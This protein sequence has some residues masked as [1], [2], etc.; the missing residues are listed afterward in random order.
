MKMKNIRSARSKE[1]TEKRVSVNFTPTEYAHFLTMKEESGVGSMSLFIKARVFN[2]TFRVIKVD[3][4]LDYYQKLTTLYGKF[5]SVGVNYNQTVVAMKR[6]FT[7]KKAF[8]MLAKLEK[9]TLELAII[10]GKIVQLTREFQEKWQH[11]QQPFYI[12]LF[13][14]DEKIR[15]PSRLGKPD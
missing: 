8:A 12:V 4:S 1:K 7:E 14:M 13:F 6:N 5:R 9:L 2:E 3:R 10:G 11:R 15:L